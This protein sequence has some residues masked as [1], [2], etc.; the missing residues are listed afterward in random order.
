MAFVT[1]M[2][3]IAQT[4]LK[5]VAVHACL[6]LVRANALMALKNMCTLGCSNPMPAMLQQAILLIGSVV[7]PM[8]V[9]IGY[10]IPS[11]DGVC[12]LCSSVKAALYSRLLNHE[13]EQIVLRS[14]V[15]CQ[16]LVF[17]GSPHATD[18]AKCQP[19]ACLPIA[20]SSS[21]ARGILL[22]DGSKLACDQLKEPSFD[23]DTIN[24]LESAANFLGAAIDSQCKAEEI[25]VLDKS[26]SRQLSIRDIL[27]AGLSA[28]CRQLAFTCRISIWQLCPTQIRPTN[29]NSNL[30]IRLSL[31]LQLVS[32]HDMTLSTGSITAI[33]YLDGVETGRTSTQGRD[34]LVSCACLEFKSEFFIIPLSIDWLSSLLRVELWHRESDFESDI[35][36]S[37]SLLGFIEMSGSYYLHLP[38]SSRAY[39]LVGMKHQH[40]SQP[41]IMMDINIQTTSATKAAQG[42]ARYPGLG[43]GNHEKQDNNL[44]LTSISVSS[45]LQ[46]P[47]LYS[48]VFCDGNGVEFGR[49]PPSSFSLCPEWTNLGIPVALIPEMGIKLVVISPDLPSQ[50][51]GSATLPCHSLTC[52]PRSATEVK[53]RLPVTRRNP[54]SQE[55]ITDVGAAQAV[56][57]E[58]GHIVLLLRIGQALSKSDRSK[59]H[60]QSNTFDFVDVHITSTCRLVGR[61]LDFQRAEVKLP[62]S[63]LSDTRSACLE[64][65]ICHRRFYLRVMN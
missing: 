47:G 58:A 48:C 17:P 50:V 36:E 37:A 51:I 1:R 52:L 64:R 65:L 62:S 5:S 43:V 26:P 31:F 61:I 25:S 19:W 46:F 57:H 29:A 59:C 11:E 44:F 34:N 54:I 9:S 33:I 38:V 2:T 18:L 30:P 55:M 8:K 35:I 63:V 21:I 41:R 45:M 39:T 56:E 10:L 60:W 28:I 6:D 20:H 12:V 53:L 13:R 22:V 32:I 7:A 40:G 49:T 16:P 14:I 42:V 27:K 24:F 4:S 3:E 23:P 15:T